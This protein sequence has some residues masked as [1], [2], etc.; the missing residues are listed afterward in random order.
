MT[1]INKI[2][3]DSIHTL[4]S[5]VLKG[6]QNIQQITYRNKEIIRKGNASYKIIF[7]FHFKTCKGIKDIALV[8]YMRYLMQ[9]TI[10]LHDKT[11]SYISFSDYQITELKYHLQV[12]FY[13][14]SSFN[15]VAASDEENRYEEDNSDKYI[16]N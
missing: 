11:G 1:D 12:K 3:D 15:P 4:M 16:F 6:Y 10:Y 2:I 14:Y 7:N 9:Q 13:K 8:S 5:T